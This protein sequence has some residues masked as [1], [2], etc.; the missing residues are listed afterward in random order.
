MTA[1]AT[2]AVFLIQRF[3]IELQVMLLADGHVKIEPYQCKEENIRLWSGIAKTQT[4]LAQS[5]I[6]VN[7]GGHYFAILQAHFQHRGWE[8]KGALEEEN[9]PFLL[10]S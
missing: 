1:Q 6:D 3:S 7:R 9:I 8:V 10:H 2:I 5:Q 4:V